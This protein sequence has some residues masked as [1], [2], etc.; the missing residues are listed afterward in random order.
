[1]QYV[2]ISAY[3]YI[4]AVLHGEAVTDVK[5]YPPR[6]CAQNYQSRSTL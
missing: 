3:I 6:C 2:Y 5:S 1:M 4:I